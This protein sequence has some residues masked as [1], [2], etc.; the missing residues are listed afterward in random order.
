MTSRRAAFSLEASTVTRDPSMRA[1]VYCFI[2]LTSD[3]DELSPDVPPEQSR[4][5]DP[6]LV[7]VLF[8]GHSVLV[9]LVQVV[10]S[11]S[12]PLRVCLGEDRDH[13]AGFEPPTP[14]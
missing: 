13:V 10:C 8:A 9:Q 5:A 11:R 3:L 2:S 14:T 7:H 12:L 4:S 6:D 1:N